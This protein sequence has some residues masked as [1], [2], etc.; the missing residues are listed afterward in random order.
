VRQHN[1]AAHLLV[2]VTAV[3]AEFHV[4]FDRLIKL[5]LAGLHGEIHR[6]IDFIKV[7]AVDQLGAVDIFLTVF[8]WFFLPVD[9]ASGGVLPRRIRPYEW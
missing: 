2:R 8:H 4:D 7:A 1:R 3:D 6:L 9:T 5:C